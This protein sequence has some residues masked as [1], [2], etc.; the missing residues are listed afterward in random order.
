MGALFKK[1]EEFYVEHDKKYEELTLKNEYTSL[2]D[3]RSMSLKVIQPKIHAV[4]L[5][6][7]NKD[8]FAH[9]VSYSSGDDY[10]GMY[11]EV[12]SVIHSELKEE[13]EIRLSE[14]L[15]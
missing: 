15:A 9:F 5:K 6:L 8:L 14:W 3:W 2:G 13:I 10:D 12:G 11:T 7:S 4:V 1:Y